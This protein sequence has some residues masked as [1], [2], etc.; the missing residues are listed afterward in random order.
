MMECFGFSGLR[1]YHTGADFEALP[2]ETDVPVR[3]ACTG[4]LVERK[5]VSGY[6]GVAVQRC[7]LFGQAVGWAGGSAILFYAMT[8]VGF[9]ST[10]TTVRIAMS[11]VYL[12]LAGFPLSVY[13]LFYG[14]WLLGIPRMGVREWLSANHP[15]AHWLLISAHPVIDLSLIPLGLVFLGLLWRYGERLQREAR[16]QIVF[17]LALLGTSLAVALSLGIHSALV[18]IRL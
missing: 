8:R 10:W 12:G 11:L 1:G 4:P 5:W 2:G 6:G 7:T 17:W 15:D 13:H 3:A 16:L 18:H 14:Q 9:G